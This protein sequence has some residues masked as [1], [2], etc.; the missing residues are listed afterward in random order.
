MPINV[1]LPKIGAGYAQDLQN[2][3]EPSRKTL[4][5]MFSIPSFWLAERQ[6]GPPSRLRHPQA[7]RC[8]PE[9]SELGGETSKALRF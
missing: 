7:A 1:P 2:P 9:A 4:A 5:V 6:E 3:L 8:L